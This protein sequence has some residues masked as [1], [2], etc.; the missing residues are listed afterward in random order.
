MSSRICSI[1]HC[2]STH[3]S[4]GL[5]AAHYK[6]AQRNG[7]FDDP[8]HP[9]CIMTGCRSAQRYKQMCSRHY[10][11][12]QRANM[13]RALNACAVKPCEGGNYRE[14]HCKEHYLERYPKTQTR[15][16]DCRR[17]GCTQPQFRLEGCE[18]HYKIYQRNEL[19]RTIVPCKIIGCQELAVKNGK[20]ETHTKPR[21]L[22]AEPECNR[23]IFSGELCQSH[24][25]QMKTDDDYKD[26]FWAFVQQELKL[27]G[28]TK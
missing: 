24:F 20:C 4:K 12:Q 6:S 10:Q 16:P 2:Y 22:C 23:R 7:A 15:I 21:N 1:E 9:T 18:K 17:P 19:R 26:D 27:E 11:I 5:C 14:G 3:K 13:R 8:N 28:A 25:H